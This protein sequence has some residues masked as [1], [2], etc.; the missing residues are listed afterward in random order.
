MNFPKYLFIFSL[1][2]GFTSNV[3][4]Q[5]PV[6]YYFDVDGNS[7]DGYFDQMDYQPENEI[8]H[9]YNSDSYE[10]G[11]YLDRSGYKS[12]GF[13]KFHSKRIWYKARLSGDEFKLKPEEVLGMVIGR[14][15]FFVA[16]EFKINKLIGQISKEDKFVRHL[17]SFSDYHF[18]VYYDFANQGIAP[19]YLVKKGEGPWQTASDFEQDL[20]VFVLEHFG[21]IPYIK[22]KVE[23]N[24]IEQKDLPMMVSMLEYYHH[25]ES[26]QPLFYDQW[27]NR[28]QTQDRAYYTVKVV[29]IKGETLTLEYFHNGRKIRSAEVVSVHPDVQEG[30]TKWFDDSG[31]LRKEVLFE[32]NEAKEVKVYYSNGQLHYLYKPVKVNLEKNLYSPI[33]EVVND[34]NGNSLLDNSGNGEEVISDEVNGRRIIRIYKSKRIKSSS[35]SDGGTNILQ[36]QDHLF[37]FKVKRLTSRLELYLAEKNYY[38]T[39]SDNAQG[40][41]MISFII[42][43]ESRY[44]TSYKVLNNIHPELD[45]LLNDFLAVTIPEGAQYRFKFRAYK[46][47]KEKQTYEVV[48]PF[49]FGVTRFYRPP[50][51]NHWW[52][53]HHM[54]HNMHTPMVP[55]NPPPIPGRY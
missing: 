20:E 8:S 37:N 21:H 26:Q 46:V 25:F 45:N 9:N 54:M 48:V 15:S 40:T 49:T 19:N 36:L 4:A 5:I 43:S 35:F 11:Y 22:K 55:I 28:V 16:N 34:P 30:V 7:I 3:N 41:Y 18:A 39:I 17:A 6:G 2:L 24:D 10:K 12:E 1:A 13:L 14:D 32:D 33:F 52:F 53:H 27:W 23:K 47:G 38:E 44:A 31:K 29:S 51:N 42:D 50:N